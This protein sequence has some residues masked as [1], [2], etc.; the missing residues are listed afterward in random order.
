MKPQLTHL[1][2]II[3]LQKRSLA[4]AELEYARL[5]KL[6]YAVN[7]KPLLNDIQ[8]FKQ[9]IYHFECMKGE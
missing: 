6:T 1:D 9:V 7:L 5:M 4:K 2:L 8:L 3:D